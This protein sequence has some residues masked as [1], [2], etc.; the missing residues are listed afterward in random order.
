[1]S[2]GRRL[3]A[4]EHTLALG[5]DP[6]RDLALEDCPCGSEGH[7]LLRLFFDR[8]TISGPAFLA[9]NHDL[10]LSPTTRRRLRQEGLVFL[11]SGKEGGWPASWWMAQATPA[12]LRHA[13][14]LA[15]E[16]RHAGECGGV[17]GLDAR[18]GTC[19]AL[20]PLTIE[21]ARQRL[22]TM[23]AGPSRDQE[24]WASQFVCPYHGRGRASMIRTDKCCTACGTMLVR[25]TPVDS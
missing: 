18:C 6:S 23:S 2:T 15:G 3:D 16:E 24:L 22:A 10:Q 13:A 21:L 20:R 7:R 25:R 14:Q 11:L 1:M 19:G 17:W 8:Q 9:S 4:S 5:I 12:G